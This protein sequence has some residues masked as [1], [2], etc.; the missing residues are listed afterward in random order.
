M[1]NIIYNEVSGFYPDSSNYDSPHSSEYDGDIS[2]DN[3]IIYSDIDNNWK[4]NTDLHPYSPN[5]Y[6]GI[7]DFNFN[8]DFLK[9]VFIIVSS[10]MIL[11]LIVN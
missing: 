8:K 2:V 5:T 9:N 4:C 1:D 6:L 11:Y 3:N 10:A 7:E